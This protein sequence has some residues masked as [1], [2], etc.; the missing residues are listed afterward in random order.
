[1]NP[2]ERAEIA[3]GLRTLLNNLRLIGKLAFGVWL[4]MVSRNL[5][6]DVLSSSAAAQV[7][8]GLLLDGLTA[9][10]S[11]FDAVKP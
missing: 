7:L 10:F 4:F 8:H 1:M 2:L 11:V 6:G 3:N 5:L 9:F